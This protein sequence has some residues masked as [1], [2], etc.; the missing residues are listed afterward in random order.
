VGSRARTYNG[1]TVTTAAKE[2]TTSAPLPVLLETRVRGIAPKDANAIG[3]ELSVSSTLRWGSWQVYDG[4]AVDRLVGLDYFGARYMSSAQ[5]RWTTPDYTAK[6]SDPVPVPS[7]DFDFPQSLNLYSYVPNNPLSNVD[8]DGHDCVVQT[9]NSETSET[10]SVTSGNCD[11][12]S[13]GDGQTKT[14]IAGV[15]DT[16]SIASDGSGGITFGYTPYSGDGG[17]ADLN[18]APIATHLPG[19]LPIRRLKRRTVRPL[20]RRPVR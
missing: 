14:Y 11:K 19:P 20:P 18:A 6:G 15:V 12:I 13:V 9:R 8:S 7:A 3:P 2:E 5:G 1:I 4:T 16:S 10:V 17:V